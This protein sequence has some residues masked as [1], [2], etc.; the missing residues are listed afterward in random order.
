MY[1]CWNFPGTL[2]HSSNIN[3]N[4]PA[5]NLNSSESKDKNA[6]LYTKLM[7]TL[8]IHRRE[9]KNRKKYLLFHTSYARLTY[10]SDV[11]KC[12]RAACELIFRKSRVCVCVCVCDVRKRRWRTTNDRNPRVN[13]FFVR[14]AADGR[15]FQG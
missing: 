1:I 15:S 5:Y 12:A 7:E 4:E 14:D 6:L 8:Y 3:L 13:G 11:S 2:E 10:V 9:E